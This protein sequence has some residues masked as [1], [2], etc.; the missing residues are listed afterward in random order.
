[1]T[2]NGGESMNSRYKDFV[3]QQ[4]NSNSGLRKIV[5]FLPT[6][7]NKQ[8]V[9]F[10]H[11]DPDGITSAIIFKRLT[12][13]LDIKNEVFFPYTFPLSIEEVQ[14]VKKNYNP[15]SI[16]ILD[17]G[18]LQHYND[19]LPKIVNNIVVVDHHPAI[20]SKFDKIIIYNPAIQNYLRTSNSLLIH[21]ISTVFQNTTQY[22]DFIC[23]IGMKC[24]WACDPLN[25]DIPDFCN[26]FFEDRI[27]PNFKWLI[28]KRTNIRP[29]MFDIKNQT[30]S[31]LLNSVSE[32][33]FALTGGGFQ[34]FYNSYDEKLR[35][36]D[37]PKFCFNSFLSDI[38]LTEFSTTDEFVN[39]VQNNEII[40]LIYQYFVNDWENTEK[41][42]DNQTIFSGIV[43]GVKIF[44]FFGN[45][46]KLMPMVGSKK[47]YE[48]AGNNE[49]AIIMFNIESDS[50]IHISFRANTD[51]I[52]L[53]KVASQLAD[54]LNSFLPDKSGVS[55][56]GHPF[57]AEC[58]IKSS[59]IYFISVLEQIIKILSSN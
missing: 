17:K 42:F 26:P 48:Y 54:V 1:M 36:V 27:L 6:L 56:G 16:F 51:K 3:Q 18:T 21:I 58:K 53:G 30:I 31:C 25:N 34:Y 12:D 33:F 41:K 8:I 28:E 35:F 45:D 50:N 46:V 59:Q 19:D 10:A 57:A 7:K 55:G 14:D 47:L 52:H 20:G 24:D 29:T 44:F 43:K 13:K 40:K 5:E 49:A 2:N 4:L 38:N 15:H 11:D 32:L 9:T 37:Q 23:L 39:R 22:D